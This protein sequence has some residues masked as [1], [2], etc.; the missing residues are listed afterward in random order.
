ML[1]SW[2][3]CNIL[4]SLRSRRGTTWIMQEERRELVFNSVLLSKCSLAFPNQLL[5][6]FTLVPSMQTFEVELGL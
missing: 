4:F 3:R 6:V 5:L 2:R 1:V